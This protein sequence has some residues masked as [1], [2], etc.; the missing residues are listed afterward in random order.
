M[1]SEGSGDLPRIMSAIFSASII[2]GA[3][4]LPV[5]MCGMIDAST[6]RS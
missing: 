3:L 6:T 1:F 5:V 2:V 4:V